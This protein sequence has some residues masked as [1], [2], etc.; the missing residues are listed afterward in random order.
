MLSKNSNLKGFS[1]VAYQ[2]V[3]PSAKRLMKEKGIDIK[4]FSDIHVLTKEKIMSYMKGVVPTTTRQPEIKF[5]HRVHNVKE[6]KNE[7]VEQ[8]KQNNTIIQKTGVILQEN[9]HTSISFDNM[10]EDLHIDISKLN[11]DKTLNKLKSFILKA[12]HVSLDK[13]GIKLNETQIK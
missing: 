11:D 13:L 7:E 1:K 2:R 12:S 4:T 6:S 9:M 3:F 5:P 8:S 10:I